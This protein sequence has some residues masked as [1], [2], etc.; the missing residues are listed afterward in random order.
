MRMFRFHVNLLCCL[1]Y[2]I[3]LQFITSV[4]LFSLGKRGSSCLSIFFW[5]GE[6]FKEENIFLR[7]LKNRFMCHNSDLISS[8]SL[9]L[10]S[11]SFLLFFNFL[12]YFRLLRFFFDS[13]RLFGDRAHEKSIKNIEVDIWDQE[14][15]TI[16]VNCH[17]CDIEG[18]HIQHKS[19]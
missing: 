3:H 9:P 13:L 10:N 18:V 4:I 17:I 16:E 11:L 1:K 5:R 2:V 14:D 7:F 8:H 19:P 12:V 15:K 6:F